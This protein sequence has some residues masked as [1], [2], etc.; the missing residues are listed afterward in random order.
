[1]VSSASD[2]ESSSVLAAPVP[3]TAPDL[4]VFSHLPTPHTIAVEFY[5]DPKM[6][7]K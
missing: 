2:A 5:S 4:A 3:G 6:I 1:M 7:K